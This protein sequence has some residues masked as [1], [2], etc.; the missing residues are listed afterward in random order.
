MGW[1]LRSEKS[2]RV[3]TSEAYV[4][5]EKSNNRDNKIN[6]IKMISRF[7]LLCFEENRKV[8]SLDSYV[9]GR[10]QFSAT[11]HR[12]FKE[13]LLLDVWNVLWWMS[14]EMSLDCLWKSSLRQRTLRG[15]ALETKVSNSWEGPEGFNSRVEWTDKTKVQSR[16]KLLSICWD[17]HWRPALAPTGRRGPSVPAVHISSQL[18]VQGSHI[19]YLKLAM[20]G[21]FPPWN[22]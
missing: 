11:V 16:L 5:S 2:R 4:Q 22:P 7:A 18:H 14:E 10:E 1:K 15:K 19:S 20:V 9:S 3:P 8:H 13:K 6:K 21:I 17:T 12:W